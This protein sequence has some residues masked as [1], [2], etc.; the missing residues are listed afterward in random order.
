MATYLID[1]ENVNKDGLNGVSKLTEE[2][3]VII[4]YSARADRMT[5]GL[6]RRLNETKAVIEY[7]RVD[8][9]GHNALD[10]QLATYLGFLISSDSSEEYC[11]VSNDRGFEF[12][13][14]FWREPLYHVT[15]TREIAASPQAEERRHQRAQ[16]KQEVPK[17]P[18][19][20]EAFRPES[21]KSLEFLETVESQDSPEERNTD[22]TES[23]SQNPVVRV[24]ERTDLIVL[25]TDQ[26]DLFS[27]PVP[28]PHSVV[29]V[30][31]TTVK[32]EAPAS[33]P[34]T[35]AENTRK[36]ASTRKRR[37]RSSG[38]SAARA[39]VN[40]SEEKLRR[41]VEQSVSELGLTEK[42]REEITAFIGRY[43]TKLGLN[44]ALV[45]QFGTQKAGEI[46]KSIKNL[47]RDKKGS[48]ETKGPSPQEEA[49][50]KD[51]RNCAAGTDLTEEEMGIIASYVLRYKTKQGLNNALVRQF[52]SQKAGM[53]YKLIRPLISGKKEK[54]GA[55]GRRKTV[56]PE[57]ERLNAELDKLLSGT[58][59]TVEDRREI[60]SFVSHY[61]TRQGVNNALVRRFRSQK[62]GEIYK[63]IK[64][65]L[66]DK[67]SRNHRK[68][69]T[70]AQRGTS[71]TVSE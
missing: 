47:I 71:T 17:L 2:D 62:A 57:E 9:G 3:K 14:G 65:L 61:K 29:E 24:E 69:A 40:P 32:P 39:T 37:S 20:S 8:V 59:L 6:H 70:E 5:F 38:R 30:L 10:F 33:A 44:N 19:A 53:I 52:G 7:R 55:T 31:E 60:S 25:R 21:P 28:M 42:D 48:A 4:F 58:D 23:A 63:L 18:E 15:R 36:S 13:A 41:D 12:L 50:L 35:A 45:R 34:G 16:E 46:Y 56:S 26:E 27:R 1:Y 11:I 67:K 68:A 22:Y 64:P 66:K 49:I 51:V 54:T 43:K